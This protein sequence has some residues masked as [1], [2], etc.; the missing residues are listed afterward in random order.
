M[1]SATPALNNEPVFLQ[2]LKLLDPAVYAEVSVD[3]LR[4][5]LTARAGLGRILLGLQPNLPAV[6]LRNR[7][8]ELRNEM[9]GDFDVQQLLDAASEALE[10]GSREVLKEAIDG[11]RT[12]VAEIY[13]VH[14]RMLRSRRT[15]A[16]HA[17]YRVTGRKAPEPLKLESGVLAETTKLLEVW[18]Q[19]ALAAHEADPVALG[20]AA[21]AFAEAVN[22]SLDPKALANWASCRL[23]ATSGEQTALD[24]IVQD[25][26][27][28][29]RRDAVAQPIAD[30]LSYLFKDKELVVVFCPTT[31]LVT[32]QP[33]NSRTFSP[34]PKCSS[35]V[36]PIPRSTSS[37]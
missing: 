9:S 14:R 3:D 12:H 13:R 30:A 29:N 4:K 7:L 17:T 33:Q 31:D 34:P 10:A 21:R 27:F 1:L 2:M 22:L 35:T 26:A 23:A 25:L 32:D 6:L 28:T 36:L 37:R 16:L 15:S 20:S 8:R 5:R 18:R 11:I 24:R 19:E